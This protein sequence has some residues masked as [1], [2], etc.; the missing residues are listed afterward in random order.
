MSAGSSVTGARSST[1]VSPGSALAGSTAGEAASSATPIEGVDASASTGVVGGAAD[2]SEAP[3][4]S[5]AEAGG[6]GGTSPSPAAGDIANPDVPEESLEI[7]DAGVHPSSPA[8]DDDA[9]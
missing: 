9:S 5:S 1:E 7:P 8:T 3:A 4:P 2:A 6:S